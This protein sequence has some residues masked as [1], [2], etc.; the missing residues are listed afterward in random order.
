[1]QEK[2]SKILILDYKYH[3][4]K[5]FK[6]KKLIFLNRRAFILNKDKFIFEDFKILSHLK[7]NREQRKKKYLYLNEL[8]NKFLNFLVQKFNI[9]NNVDFDKKQWNILVG[10]WLFYYL[11]ACYNKYLK[12]HTAFK[13]N[14]NLKVYI[15]KSDKKIKTF[16]TEDFLKNINLNDSWNAEIYFKLLSE[17]KKKIVFSIIK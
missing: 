5:N 8:H 3:K 15:E 6:K 13:I 16:S 10:S 9:I 2:I 12:L 7:F 17:M 4:K 14:R 1:M 11:N